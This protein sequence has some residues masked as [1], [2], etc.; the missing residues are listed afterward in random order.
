MYK[1]IKEMK[2]KHYARMKGFLTYDIEERE[3]IEQK[4]ILEQC[5]KAC[6]ELLQKK[7]IE[8]ENQ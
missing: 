7:L 1:E 5:I 3:L 2:R 8:L 4:I 6:E